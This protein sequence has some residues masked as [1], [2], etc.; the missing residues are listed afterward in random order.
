MT[1][2]ACSFLP[3]CLPA[4]LPSRLSSCIY[5]D[6]W[7]LCSRS[8]VEPLSAF[9]LVC[10]FPLQV[11]GARIVRCNYTS[12]SP[13]E[14]KLAIGSIWELHLLQQLLRALVPAGKPLT[15]LELTNLGHFVLSDGAACLQGCSLLQDL[16]TLC[17]FDCHFGSVAL[18]RMLS[19]APQLLEL[20]IAASLQGMLPASLISRQGLRKLVLADNRLQQLPPGPYLSGKQACWKH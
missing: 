20:V 1:A 18:D 8:A 5:S 14:G 11:G 7:W 13:G 12:E 15:W 2:A 10:A 19:Q 6:D 3:A 9:A 16:T 4:C 17:M